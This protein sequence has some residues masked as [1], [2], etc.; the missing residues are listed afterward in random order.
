MRV[1]QQLEEGRVALLQVYL[2]E[3][4]LRLQL[5]RRDAR[6]ALGRFGRIE[7]QLERFGLVLNRRRRC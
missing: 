3:C 4:R 7:D 6:L 1:P 5:G 2:G